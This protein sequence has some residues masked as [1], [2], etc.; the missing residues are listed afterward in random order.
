MFSK[1]R[2]PWQQ[3]L[4]PSTSYMTSTPSYH[5]HESEMTL[6]FSN[7]ETDAEWEL[8]V[9]VCS[10]YEPGQKGGWE[11]PSWDPYFH[12]PVAYYFRPGHGWKQVEL[13]DDQEEAICEHFAS[14]LRPRSRRLLGA[15]YDRY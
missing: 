12:S 4:N 11:D 6:S 2:T 9:T 14:G 13:T 7:P 15:R 3:R 5:G 8:E 10:E 1:N